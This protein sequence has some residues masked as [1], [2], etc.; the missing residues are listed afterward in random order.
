MSEQT[1]AS[2]P[3]AERVREALAELGEDPGPLALGQVP[4]GASRETWMVESADG[5]R[6]VLRRDPPGGVPTPLS[7]EA[8]FHVMSAAHAAGAPVPRPLHFEPEGGRFG[9][10]G[11]LME[12]VAGETIARRL[13]THL[14]YAGALPRLPDSIAW[15]LARVHSVSTATVKDVL[16][17]PDR[18][19]AEQAVDAWQAALEATGEPLPVA[20]LGL[21]WLR[22]NR[23]PPGPLTLVH[24][25]FRLGNFA[26]SG[27]GLEAV[28]DWELCHLGDPAEDVG[29]LCVRSWRYGGQGRVAGLARLDDFLAAY[30]RLGGPPLEPERVHFWEVLGNVKWAIICAQQAQRHLSGAERSLELA[31]LGRRICEPEWDFLSLVL[32]GAA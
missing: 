5:H 31:S 7:R 8:E 14:E 18:D 26:V 10:A 9:A 1:A 11:L 4:G 21:R 2:E 28:L 6:W 12:F 3:A 22:R 19:P 17:T 24:G 27:E 15:A 30:E 20:E 16:G 32:E 23:P 29:W 13:L 25:D